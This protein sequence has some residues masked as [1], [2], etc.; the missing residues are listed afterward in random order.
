MVLA[1]SER[2]IVEATFAQP[3]HVV[4]THTTPTRTYALGQIAVA[5]G[6]NKAIADSLRDSPAVQAEV[7]AFAPYLQAPPDYTLTVGLDMPG[8][9]GMEA[10]GVHA[11]HGGHGLSLIHI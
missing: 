4:L 6:D 8:M 3:G 11:G 1:P 9:G 5:T 10:G 7:A 2:V